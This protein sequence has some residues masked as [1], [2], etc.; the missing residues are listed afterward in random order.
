VGAWVEVEVNERTVARE[1]TVGAGHAGG[2]SGW[3]HAGLGEAD[4][5]EVRIQ[6]PDGETGPWITV[7]ADQFVTIDR[8]AT[9]ATPWLPGE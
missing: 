6:W 9:E 2:K 1:V 7:G 3:L 5:A 8:G 4:Q